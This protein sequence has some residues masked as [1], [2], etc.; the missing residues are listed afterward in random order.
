[1]SIFSERLKIMRA[2]TRL[3]QAEMAEKLGTTIGNYQCYEMGKHYP[4]S[5][6]LPIMAEIFDCSIDALFYD[7]PYEKRDITPEQAI[8]AL[9]KFIDKTKK[10]EV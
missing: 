8:N 3:T 7:R 6:K 4:I 5:D 10:K 9:I 1:M 2:A